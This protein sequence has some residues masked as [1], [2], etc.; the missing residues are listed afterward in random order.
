MQH[1]LVVLVAVLSI[2]VVVLQR[3][4]TIVLGHAILSRIEIDMRTIGI[5]EILALRSCL[6]GTIDACQHL[7][8]A[9]RV[10]VLG[11]CVNQV[12]LLLLTR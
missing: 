11:R 12:W 4:V 2:E 6:F 7:L 8:G 5:A 9:G 3:L 10:V 1:H